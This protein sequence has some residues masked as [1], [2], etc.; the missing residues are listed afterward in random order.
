MIREI[1]KTIN[2][3]HNL[4]IFIFLIVSIILAISDLLGALTI[5]ILV[6]YITDGSE[7]F[8]KKIPYLFEYLGSDKKEA[9]INIFILN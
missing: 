9:F 6:S 4:T 7:F 1:F 8:K 3:R 2:N 5:S